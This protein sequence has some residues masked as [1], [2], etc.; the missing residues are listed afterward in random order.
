MSR[1]DKNKVVGY[2]YVG[3]WADGSI[4]W[5]LPTHIAGSQTPESPSHA[6]EEHASGELFEL[7][8]ITV[9]VVHGKRRR[10]VKR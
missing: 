3:R 1:S 2:G 4:G 5:F 9:E 7:C 10:R 8:K 6:A